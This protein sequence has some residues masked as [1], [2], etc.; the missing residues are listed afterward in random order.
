MIVLHKSLKRSDDLMRSVK[1]N[2]EV[3]CKTI[4]GVIECFNNKNLQGY[5]IKLFHSYNRDNDLAIWLYEPLKDKN[6]Q[7]KL[8]SKVKLNKRYLIMSLNIMDLMK[9]LQGKKV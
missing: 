8:K 3:N 1:R 6:I 4:S 2:F 5:M 7:L 9:K